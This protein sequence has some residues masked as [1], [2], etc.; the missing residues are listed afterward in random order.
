MAE[1]KAKTALKAEEIPFS[2]AT[3]FYEI[4]R[5]QLG[6]RDLTEHQRELAEYLI[7]SLDD[8]G[9]LRKSLESIGDELAIYAGINAKR[10]IVLSMVIAGALSGLGG[11]IYY[12]SGTAQYTIVKSL[13]AMGFNGIPV[14][15][16]AT[17]NPIGII[18]SSIFVSYIQVGGEAMQP[19]FAKEIID[20]IISVIIYLSA[21]ALL[22]KG[23]IKKIMSIRK[24]KQ[25]EG[26]SQ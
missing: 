17:S 1:I 7:G 26:V 6:E 16:L 8:D 9:L 3:S 25:G 15:L 21:F 10:N 2:D 24:A 5:E 18:F 13:L 4:L 19:E 20:I 22:L 23:V 12:L 14:A 11:G